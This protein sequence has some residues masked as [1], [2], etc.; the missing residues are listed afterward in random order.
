M[1][2]L[3]EALAEAGYQGLI[4]E[5]LHVALTSG[6][7]AVDYHDIVT[8]VEAREIHP[9]LLDT[10]SI[11][12]TLL[13]GLDDL[14][15]AFRVWLLAR[16]Q[17]FH[18]VL[19]RGLERGLVDGVQVAGR[20]RQ[21]AQAILNL[22]PT[23]EEA[24][25]A[26]MRLYAEDGDVGSALREYSALWNVLDSEYAME[27][28]AAT[29]QLVADI[30]Q[31]VFETVTPHAVAPLNPETMRDFAGELTVP[32]PLTPDARA[33]PKL[34]LLIE[35]FGM[36][37]IPPDSLHLA[38]GFRHELIACLVRFR[39]WFVVDGAT[40]SLDETSGVRVAGVYCVAATVY[41]AGDAMSL[42]LTL[43]ERG[44]GIHVWSDRFLLA[45]P[46]WFDAQQHIVRQIAL[47]LNV[48]VS[49][50]RLSRV[51]SEPA[52]S[53][54][55]YDLWLRG[56]ASLHRF[57]PDTWQHA[58]DMF[59]EAITRAPQF[60]PG[61]SSL[62]QMNNIV[63]FVHPGLRRDAGRTQRTVA[64]ARK[65]V[66]LDP[67]DSRSQLCLGWSYAMADSFVPASTHMELAAALNPNDSWTLISTGL[68]LSY[69]G[70]VTLGSD[71]ATQAERL[72]LTPARLHWAYQVQ[73]A[74]LRGDDAEAVAAADRAQDVMRGMVAWRAAALW[75]LGRR[76]EAA[77]TARRF[78]NLIRSN[79][80]GEGPPTD[81]AIGRWLLHMF[82]FRHATDWQRLREGLAG[83]GIAVAGAAH[84]DW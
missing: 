53:L 9:R 35:Q 18:D 5:R 31:G 22:D 13:E 64:L 74:F 23:H 77:Q 37:G 52:V 78:V 48:Q 38:A 44:T 73:I 29:Q 58:A 59:T 26:V 62:V 34:A 54:E 69:C 19:L 17:S 10:P 33:P 28:S 55:A 80:F 30:K 21:M 79:W 51:A 60:A 6:Q 81:E 15:P 4:R 71:L 68:C 32:A 20:R 27:P 1:H 47:S 36:N 66:E 11:G 25:R 12:D 84:G 40:L 82:P 39:D 70:N 16:R 42:V 63:H 57:S 49:M 7:D 45:L 65:A 43:R 46:T 14:D 2:E 3:G 61:Y 75:H 76:E 8:A 67:M 83:A 41:Q 24:C 72:A 56:Q 50:G